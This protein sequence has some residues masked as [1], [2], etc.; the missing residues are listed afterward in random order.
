MTLQMQK[1]VVA[2]PIKELLIIGLFGRK[3]ERDLDF[4]HIRRKFRNVSFIGIAYSSTSRR[5]R[6]P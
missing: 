6:M 2:H 5:H 4:V 1:A 3:T